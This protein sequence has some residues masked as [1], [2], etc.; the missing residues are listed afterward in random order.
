MED[1]HPRFPVFFF[2]P[3]YQ[4]PGEMRRQWMDWQRR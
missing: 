2:L 4:S 1:H 3:G